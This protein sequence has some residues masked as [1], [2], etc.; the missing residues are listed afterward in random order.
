MP[1]VADLRLRLTATQRSDGGWAYY[2]GKSSRLEP[3]CWAIVAL[4]NDGAWPSDRREGAVRYL[5]GRQRESGLLAESPAVGPNYGWNGLALLALQAAGVPADTTAER[6]IVV[7]LLAARGVAVENTPDIIRQDGTLRA[8]SWIDQTFSWVEPTAYCMLALKRRPLDPG[9]AGRLSEAEALM[10]DRACRPAGWNY[11]NSAVLGQELRPYVPTTA[12]ALL[13]MQD[14]RQDEVVP[15]SL[16]WLEQESTAEHSAMALGLAAICLHVFERP[17][18]AVLAAIE[19]QGART[20]FLGNA[21]L[22]AVA[23]YALTLPQ[24]GGGAFRLGER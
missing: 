11:G 14:R 22:E 24:H 12:L 20:S 19:A 18:G 2:E 16:S 6:R 15:R 4:A 17:I 9:A 13:A 23:L 7:A 10:R 3:T 8:W 5:L 21:H 1:S